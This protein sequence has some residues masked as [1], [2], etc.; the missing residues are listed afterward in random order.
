MS[1]AIFL[2]KCEDSV[3]IAKNRENRI[4]TTGR[5]PLAVVMVFCVTSTM[6]DFIQHER[7]PLVQPIRYDKWVDV[8]GVS[9]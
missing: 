7:R 8:G 2:R 1:R 9:G 3:L 5:R 4:T 6:N